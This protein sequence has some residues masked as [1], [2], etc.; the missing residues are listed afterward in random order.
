MVKI[1]VTHHPFDLPAHYDDDNLVGR[2]SN[3]MEMF[4]SCGIDLLL[5][6]HLHASH[7]GNTAARY[8]IKD[9][10]AL[11]VQAGTATSTRGRGESNSFNVIRT[12]SDLMMVERFSW[13]QDEGAFNLATTE[14]FERTESGWSAADTAAR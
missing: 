4:A 3:A 6:G 14:T 10:S 7:A 9:Y 5:A 1:V 13:Q 8:K 12:A 11:A 2:A